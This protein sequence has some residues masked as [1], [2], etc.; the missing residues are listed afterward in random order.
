MAHHG[1]Q[2]LEEGKAKAMTGTYAVV[3]EHGHNEYGAYAP[4][5]P[6]TFVAAK[7]L[8]MVL[9]L[10]REAIATHLR[11]VLGMGDEL[12]APNPEIARALAR[13]T[14]PDG[15]LPTDP[16]IR[17][18]G[19]E[20]R[21]EHAPPDAPV[22]EP[23]TAQTKRKPRSETFAVVFEKVPGNWSGYVPDLPGCV[24]T[25]RTLAD[26]RRNMQEAVS[27]HSQSMVDDGES[28]PAPR[29]SSRQ[30]LRDHQEEMSE[31]AAHEDAK[32][33]AESVTVQV[34]PARPE[35]RVLHSIWRDVIKRKSAFEKACA[36]RMALPPGE[37]WNG[38]Y[39]AKILAVDDLWHG[40]VADL[41]LCNALGATR[42]ELHRNLRAAIGERLLES[43]S[44]DGTIPLPR[45]TAELAT[46]HYNLGL[47]EMGFDEFPDPDVTVEMVPVEITAPAIA[48]AS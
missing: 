31:Y 11:L 43:L 34:F 21:P 12:P 19:V 39:A 42:D 15:G 32:T 36:T 40:N 48:C 25:G 9:R 14:D 22:V 30:A 38:S 4:E 16:R 18:V 5:V 29:K 8:P 3:V 47:A 44:A 45:R 46:A 27:L 10:V 13:V 7:T 33:V 24:S 23:P 41:P 17:I 6:G 35:A 26:M 28:L 1:L 20:S 2:S 37:S